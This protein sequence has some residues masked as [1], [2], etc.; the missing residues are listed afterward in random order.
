[1][2]QKVKIELF[3]ISVPKIIRMVTSLGRTVLHAAAARDQMRIT[4]LVL[5]LGGSPWCTDQ[6]EKS[7][8]DVAML[9]NSYTCQRVLK[10][11]QRKNL[12]QR[13][14]QGLIRYMDS[15]STV[16]EVYQGNRPKEIDGK[17][18]TINESDPNGIFRC[19]KNITCGPNKRTQKEFDFDF[20]QVLPSLSIEDKTGKGQSL[21]I[22]K[23]DSDSENSHGVDLNK[24]SQSEPYYQT[25][26]HILAKQPHV[27]RGR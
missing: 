21:D 6:L 9:H 10:L 14:E 4:S 26:Y 2:K 19:E 25:K 15:K 18:S 23:K 13:G 16:N 24:R 5:S 17:V 11:A 27:Y 1:M 22:V 12:A 20:S 7:P 3:H 8:L